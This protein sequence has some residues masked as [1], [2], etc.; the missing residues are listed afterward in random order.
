M[1]WKYEIY[2]DAYPYNS[3]GEIKMKTRKLNE[4]PY[5]KVFDGENCHATGYLVCLGDQ[6]NPGDWWVEY[7]DSKGALHYG[8]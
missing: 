4:M 6:N 1:S 5:D 7:V 3:K 8:R 2:E